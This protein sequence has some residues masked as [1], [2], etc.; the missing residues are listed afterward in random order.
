M[1]L[2]IT[3]VVLPGGTR[4]S[5]RVVD[6]V[7]TAIGGEPQPGDERLDGNGRLVLP[8]MAEA[9]AHLDKAFLSERVPNPTGDL[10]GAIYGMQ[11]ARDTIT[12]DDT[13]ARAE[14]A[15]RLIAANGATAI[16]THADVTTDGG[17]TSVHA[18]LRLRDAL[19]DVVHLEVVGLCGW[20]VVGAAGAEQRALLREAIA[21]GVDAVGGCPHL[22]DDPVAANEYF[23]TVA[24]EHGLPVDLHTDETLDPSKF[25]LADLAERVIASG[26][27]HRVA[28]SHCV[29]LGVQQPDI[30]RRVAEAVAAAGI[31]VIALPSSN[32]YLQGRA[33]EQAVPRGLT[34]I[35]ALRTAGANL[36][37]GWDNLQD[38]FNPV[39]RGDCLETASLMVMAGHLLPAEAYHTVSAATRALM[40]L[41]PAGPTVGHVADLVLIDAADVREAIA[42]APT[43]R[44]VIRAGRVVT[45]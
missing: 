8:A 34:A 27:P 40:G 11:A 2:T 15:A 5:V 38:P 21:L 36:A 18:L 10:M 37:A 25:A 4:S 22:E 45:A 19:R 13:L 3:D 6:G 16:R 43:P 14:R 44:T 33:V 7:V 28:A 1:A 20:P 31:S 29:S 9:H 17:L 41:A 24:A 23:L 30:Q 26:F 32:L 42:F 12:A 35:G 39:G